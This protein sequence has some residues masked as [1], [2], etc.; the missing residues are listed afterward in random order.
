MDTHKSLKIAFNLIPDVT[1]LHWMR[2]TNE[3][4][5]SNLRTDY[6]LSTFGAATATGLLVMVK[7][8]VSRDQ[9]MQFLS[10]Q[11]C[12]SKDLW[13][14]IKSRVRWVEHDNSVRKLRR[15]ALDI[16]RRQ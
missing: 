7:P 3:K 6:L 12:I 15:V 5:F 2:F 16:M 11:E 10:A 8:D 4:S 14:Q 1:Q 13:H 9:I